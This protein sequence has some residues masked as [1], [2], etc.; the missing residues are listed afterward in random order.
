MQIDVL[1]EC[2]K[3]FLVDCVASMDTFYSNRNPPKKMLKLPTDDK[4]TC[5]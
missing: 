2:C 3:G 5:M 1:D 4:H